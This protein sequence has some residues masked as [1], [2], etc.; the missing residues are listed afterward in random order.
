[1]SR[2]NPIFLYKRREL[3]L[4]WNAWTKGG[5]GYIAVFRMLGRYVEDGVEPHYLETIH[6]CWKNGVNALEEYL[7]EQM[8]L[9]TRN[10]YTPCEEDHLTTG[11]N[12][13]N[14]QVLPT[15]FS[16]KNT[17]TVHL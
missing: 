17:S 9:C 13:P 15:S 1:M 16:W 12:L 11:L 4:F 5:L 6:G 3:I 10:G 7:E 14:A 8:S 2:L